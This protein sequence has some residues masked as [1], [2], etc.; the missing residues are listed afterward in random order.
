MKMHMKLWAVIAITFQA[1]VQA[2][3]QGY[4]VPN[5]VTSGGADTNSSFFC[6]I[7][8]PTSGD[9]T[10]FMFLSQGGGTFTFDHAVDEGVRV[11]SVSP[12]D[13][14]SLQPIQ[15]GYYMELT[16]P[17]T[18]DIANNSPFYLGVYTGYNPWDSHGNYTGIYTDPVFGWGEFVN[19][20]G[21]IE[22]LDSALEYGGGGIIVGTQNI[23]PVP[24]PSA[25]A[26]GALGAMLFILLRPRDS[27]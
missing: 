16:F 25:I 5:G 27:V 8:N 21:V 15:A 3:S 24:E 9:Y 13:P 26:L 17:N 1:I 7:Q 18:Y 2:H 12:N 11:F 19:N 6:V 4:I 20:N 10:V 14:I 22:L 23:I